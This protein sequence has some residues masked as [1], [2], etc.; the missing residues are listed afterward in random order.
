MFF[1]ISY[2][3]NLADIISLVKMYFKGYK[4]Y[5]K[6]LCSEGIAETFSWP[7]VQINKMPQNLINVPVA[8]W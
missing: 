1:I 8:Q 4:Y 7:I 6:N 3:F 5:Q 2:Q